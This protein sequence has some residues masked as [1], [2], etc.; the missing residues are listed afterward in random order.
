MRS[1]WKEW[2]RAGV[3]PMTDGGGMRVPPSSPKVGRWQPLER[4]VVNLCA[5]APSPI[6]SKT[7]VEIAVREL[8]LFARKEAPNELPESRNTDLYALFRALTIPNI[9]AL[10]E[11]ALSESR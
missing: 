3:V 1:L 2:V 7:Q 10:M 4:Y 5:E 9:V 8:R 6:S 11:F